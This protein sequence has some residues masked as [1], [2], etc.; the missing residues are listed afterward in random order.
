MSWRAVQHPATAAAALAEN[1]DGYRLN[2]S[3]SSSSS[4]RTLSKLPSSES[5]AMHAQGVLWMQRW[6]VVLEWTLKAW[7][8]RHTRSSFVPTLL[9]LSNILRA[10]IP[11]ALQN[12]QD[13]PSPNSA[14]NTRRNF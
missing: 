14:S 11:G 12:R 6:G 13:T 4:K 7:P 9:R 2:Y 1:D 8:Q 5:K 3:G 10:P